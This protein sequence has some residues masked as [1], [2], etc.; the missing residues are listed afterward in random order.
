MSISFHQVH[1]VA[2]GSA[3]TSTQ[4]NNLADGIND[5]LLSG[6]A[7]P[8]YRIYFTLL[9]M[10][11]QMRNSDGLLV[12]PSE[13]E[14]F[15][16]YQMI[17]PS[18]SYL[19]DAL[20]DEPEGINVNSPLG[21]WGCGNDAMG[22][23][24]E[25][26]RIDI[27]TLYGGLPP[28]TDFERWELRKSQIGGITPDGLSYAPVL[29]AGYNWSTLFYPVGSK[30]GASYGGYSAHADAIT[31]CTDGSDV[32]DFDVF[33]TKTDLS[34]SCPTGSTEIGDQ[35]HYSTCLLTTGSIESKNVWE[36]PWEYFVNVIGYGVVSIPKTQFIVGPYTSSVY[37]SK[38]PSAYDMYF[39][40]LQHFISE[41]RG[42]D[43][44]RGGGYNYNLDN[45][46]DYQTFFTNQYKL[47]PNYAITS[48]GYLIPQYPKFQY[49][50]GST[51]GLLFSLSA[52]VSKSYDYHTGFGLQSACITWDKLTTPFNVIF[53]QSGSNVLQTVYVS[54]SSSPP[55]GSQIVQLPFACYQ[56]ASVW[57]ESTPSWS[58]TGGYINVETDELYELTA[59]VHD[60]YA[61]LRLGSTNLPTSTSYKTDGNGF[62]FGNA[63]DVFN[64]YN[65]YGLLQ[66]VN[67]ETE[68]PTIT[69]G[70]RKNAIYD[71]F[72]RLS[73]SCRIVTR[74]QFCGYEFD[75]TS[76]I[77][78][79]TPTK[80]VNGL[81]IH[82]LGDIGPSPDAVGSVLDGIMY[83]ASGSITYLSQSYTDGQ[84]FSGSYLSS[85]FSGS[86][87]VYEYDIIKHTASVAGYSNEWMLDINLKN[88]APG[89]TD[90]YRPDVYTDY[91]GPSINRCMLF[92]WD[93]TNDFD[94]D[95]I[96]QHFS[97]GIDLQMAPEVP[98]GYNYAKNH[99][100]QGLNL[101]PTYPTTQSAFYKSCRIYEPS[102]NVLSAERLVINGTVYT[103][104]TLDGRLHH[105]DAAPA[106]IA[107]YINGVDDISDWTDDVYND[108]DYRTIE[109]GLREY[110]YK[111]D[112][113]T[114]SPKKNAGDY[115]IRYTTDVGDV[116]GA[117]YPDFRFI[118]LI[119]KVYEDSNDDM[120]GMDTDFLHD[121]FKQ[122]D[123]YLR[124]ISEGY[125]DERVTNEFVCSM[126]VPQLV[127]YTW[128]S[129]V[130]DA[131][132]K[133]TMPL[134][135]S[136]DVTGINGI[137]F[138]PI[139]NTYA[140]AEMFNAFAKITNKLTKVRVMLPWEFQYNQTTYSD[141]YTLS[142]VVDINGSSLD[143]SCCTACSKDALW[144]GSA[145]QATTYAATSGWTQAWAWS[146]QNG[147]S[148][149][150]WDCNGSSNW[151][152]LRTKDV[153]DWRVQTTDADAL[154]ALPVAIRDMVST[155]TS[156][157]AVRQTSTLQS[158]TLVTSSFEDCLDCEDDGDCRYYDGVNYY[159]IVSDIEVTTTCEMVSSTAGTVAAPQVGSVQH[160]ATARAGGSSCGSSY[161]NTITLTILQNT[162]FCLNIPLV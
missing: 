147:V 27:P 17:E 58:G 133:T 113:D 73:K 97:Y 25:N 35:C 153:F 105:H 94:F 117:I 100:G 33:F 116:W 121:S 42:S 141:R 136:G 138:G 85:E 126:T 106:V 67:G 119:P 155:N 9:S 134:I 143:T 80:T 82:T 24:D 75:G 14:F 159:N 2:S 3:I 19:P 37:I 84:T 139:P 38:R 31:G 87:T 28:A 8:A 162:D 50:S 156:V 103:K 111:L 71:T 36:S 145:G 124:S 154:Y 63:T 20:C 135:G 110:C 26:G 32:T 30:V 23:Y 109:N 99:L 57:L 68:V 95:D 74:D 53:K 115:S 144:A 43:A 62:D 102:L 151:R 107:R 52:S 13:Y 92:N 70:I 90:I 48:S 114:N 44:Q 5:R 49:I 61:L 47:S 98:S 10:I 64:C 96:K 69:E 120:D 15:S 66:N 161:N 158:A 7:D 72:R 149:A 59:G 112:S 81:T 148:M 54:A 93:I 4:F 60:A 125:V 130:Y 83:Q 157:L 18:Q 140:R 55:S 16:S 79:F 91:F 128:S 123:L 89:I 122:M 86:G 142:G 51:T 131:L 6:L 104:V 132:G 108:E 40:L 146:S 22:A 21:A 39:R 78:Y 76:S 150:D 34:A 129:L 101:E 152:V 11:R 137:S 77:L 160:Y 46:F 118:K 65:Q 41:F 56:S 88:Y 1:E 29:D 12:F 45:A 127:D